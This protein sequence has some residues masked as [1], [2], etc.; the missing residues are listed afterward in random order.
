LQRFDVVHRQVWDVEEEYR[1]VEEALE[2]VGK[3][4]MMT[5]ELHDIAH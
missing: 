5:T 4:Y 3:L 2:G 1:N